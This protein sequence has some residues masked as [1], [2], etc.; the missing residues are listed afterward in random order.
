M[1]LEKKSYKR[2]N[3]R[4]YRV[5]ASQRENGQSDYVFLPLSFS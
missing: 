2:A 4:E 1:L 5:F 3:V